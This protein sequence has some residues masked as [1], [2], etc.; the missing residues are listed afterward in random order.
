MHPAVNQWSLKSIIHEHFKEINYGGNFSLSVFF[1]K[2]D[3]QKFPGSKSTIPFT[4]KIRYKTIYFY[5]NMDQ[6]LV[7]IL[8]DRPAV[9]GIADPSC[10]QETPLLLAVSLL[11]FLLRHWQLLLSFLHWFLLISSTSKCWERARLGPQNSWLLSPNSL[12]QYFYMC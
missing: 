11:D 7:L 3:I 8:L 10:L 2:R 6:F 1:N 4:F 12:L 5:L 9:L